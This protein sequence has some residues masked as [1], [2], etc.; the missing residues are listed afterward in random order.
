MP[1]KDKS[2]KTK[3][4]VVQKMPTKDPSEKQEYGEIIKF[5]GS[6]WV[7][8]KCMDGVE[9]RCHIRGALQR[10][11]SGPTKMI[12]GDIVLLSIRDQG[13]GDIILKYPAD[14]ARQMRK[15]GDVIF[16]DSTGPTVNENDTGF[17]FEDPESEDAEKQSKQTKQNQPTNTKSMYNSLYHSSA[18]QKVTE[19]L[20]GGVSGDTSGEI[21]FDD[22]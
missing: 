11:K 1:K 14:V 13:T 16:G 19:D 5:L 2:K 15:N 20:L 3:S 9:R 10:F 17:D 7:I 22:I 6:N 18:P 12:A 8:A 21:N 4:G